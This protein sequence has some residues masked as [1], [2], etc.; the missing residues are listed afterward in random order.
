MS[1]QTSDTEKRL[2]T[3]GGQH[4]QRKEGRTAPE[5]QGTTDSNPAVKR[6]CTLGVTGDFENTYK[7][8]KGI[9]ET[10]LT[11]HCPQRSKDLPGYIGGPSEEA[12]RLEQEK[13]GTFISLLPY[14]ITYSLSPLI[15]FFIIFYFY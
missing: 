8:E 5:V 14:I 15:F 10:D 1:G 3:R 6:G 7:P 13:E 12:T 4:E 9:S 11:P 2:A